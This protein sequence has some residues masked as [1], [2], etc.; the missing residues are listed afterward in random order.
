MG[1]I[2]AKRF[3][4]RIPFLPPTSYGN[5]TL[6]ARVHVG[7]GVDEEILM[8]RFPFAFPVF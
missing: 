4:G 6:S 5:D 7:N 8:R 1:M 2:G 3:S